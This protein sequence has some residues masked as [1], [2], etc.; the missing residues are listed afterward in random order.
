MRRRIT[1]EEQ[2][3]INKKK[4]K[5][6]TKLKLKLKR[7]NPVTKRHD[8]LKK[9]DII[10]GIIFLTGDPKIQHPVV[11]KKKFNYTSLKTVLVRINTLRQIYFHRNDD[12]F[13]LIKEMKTRPEY[14]EYRCKVCSRNEKCLKEIEEDFKRGL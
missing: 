4:Y 9:G 8:E 10:L 5:Y 14:N 12:E 6:L 11:A 13:Y 7:W 2:E 3:I 1:K